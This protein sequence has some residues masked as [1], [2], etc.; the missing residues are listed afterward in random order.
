MIQELYFFS[1]LRLEITA[2]NKILGEFGKIPPETQMLKF[3]CCPF[4]DGSRWPMIDCI[5]GICERCK[6]R[7]QV[8][9]IFCRDIMAS[10]V[11]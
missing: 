7:M 6:D 2:F 3:L 1:L 4:P 11:E 9:D 10:H 8:F 5:K